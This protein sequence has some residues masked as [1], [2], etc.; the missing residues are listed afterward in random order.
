[1]RRFHYEAGRVFR[2]V[3]R[4][5]VDSRL[6]IEVNDDDRLTGRHRNISA[7]VRPP[8]LTYLVWSCAGIEVPMCRKWC[9]VPAWKHED[10]LR[11]E[12]QCYALR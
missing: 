6:A 9:L 7:S 8:P 3:L 2:C 1:M 4:P 12:M 10:A 11:R 5:P